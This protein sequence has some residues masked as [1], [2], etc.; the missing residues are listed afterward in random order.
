MSKIKLINKIIYILIYLLI[1]YSSSTFEPVNKAFCQTKSTEISYQGSGDLQ[2]NVKEDFFI[3]KP[4]D[5]D[6]AENTDKKY[7]LLI[8]L[9]GASQTK[10]MKNLY[11]MGLGYYDP[12]D[13]KDQYQSEI[14]YKF[15]K[16][17]SCFIFLPQESGTLWNTD[18]LIKQIELL[19]RTYRIASD[20]MYL[21]GFSMGGS[22]T[23]TLAN[24]YYSYNKT[25][26][27]CIVRLTGSLKD[28]YLDKNIINKTA[29]WLHAGLKDNDDLK[30]IL[31]AYDFL[32]I[33]NKAAV[34]TSSKVSIMD[35][36]KKKHTAE[37]C[38]LTINGRE[39]VKKTL[40]KDD[41][42]YITEFPFNDPDHIDIMEWIFSQSIEK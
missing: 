32:K 15:R 42:H 11:Y 18:K 35:I 30:S 38:T 2:Y 12:P 36:L 6:T 28:P 33:S 29:I 13:F 9:H 17:Y 31:D 21:H 7:P 39:I 40:Y 14:A 8:Y 41:G 10:Y 5:Y 1:I 19:K 25:L 27:A 23:Y 22:A 37:T 26:F 4:L 16:R 34:E 24:A 20:R 3:I